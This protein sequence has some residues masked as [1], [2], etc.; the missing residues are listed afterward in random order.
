MWNFYV[1]LISLYLKGSGIT[2]DILTQAS[3]PLI[4]FMIKDPT[5]F[6]TVNLAGNGTP[7]DMMFMYI[8]KIFSDG[9]E[10][11]D[12]IYS[13]NAVALIMALLEHLGD[14]I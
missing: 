8:Q 10:L 4:N 11:E 13:M 3:A 7:L 14:G 2:E 12:E 9:R 5:T 1:H 6:K